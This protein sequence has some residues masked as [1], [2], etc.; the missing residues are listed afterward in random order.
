MAGTGQRLLMEHQGL[1]VTF[2]TTAA[3]SNGEM[4]RVEVTVA[5]GVGALKHVHP[6]QEE[7]FEA[8]EGSFTIG[9]GRKARAYGPG[10]SV[11]AP[12]GVVHWVSNKSDAAV[13]VASEFR[14]ALDS[15]SV[16]E[17]LAALDRAGKAGKNLVPTPLQIAVMMDELGDSFSYAAGHS[18]G[19]PESHRAS[20]GS[21]RPQTRLQSARPVL[22]AGRPTRRA[23][24]S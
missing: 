1:E 13:R 21:A 12:G 8:L 4:L 14:P 18:G 15:E 17:T 6:R 16:W 7:R 10:E 9:V 24:S 23:C 5:P 22:T 20:T 11:A 3:D 19:R 2:V